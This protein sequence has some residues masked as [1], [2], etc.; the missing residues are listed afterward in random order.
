MTAHRADDSLDPG[1][2]IKY[3]M[4]KVYLLTGQSVSVNGS[5]LCSNSERFLAPKNYLCALR[6]EMS[7]IWTASTLKLSAPSLRTNGFRA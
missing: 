2:V 4:S 1:T 3:R 6:L 5:V 7:R